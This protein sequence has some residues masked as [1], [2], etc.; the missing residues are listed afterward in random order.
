LVRHWSKIDD[1]YVLSPLIVNL[2]EGQVNGVLL[3]VD[4]IALTEFDRRERGYHRIEL[5]ASQ[6]KS[7][8][9]FKQDQSIWVYIKDE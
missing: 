3:E 5:K 8:S 9:E 6:I 2:G 4:D 1:S 7:Q